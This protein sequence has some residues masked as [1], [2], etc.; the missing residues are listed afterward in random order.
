MPEVDYELCVPS[1]HL[2]RIE[3]AHTANGFCE[4]I[5]ELGDAP[6]E[7]LAAYLLHRGWPDDESFI[8][9][10]VEFQLYRREHRSARTALQAIELAYGH[11]EAP[12]LAPMQ[13]E[14]VMPQSLPRVKQERVAFLSW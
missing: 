7:K 2:Q 6:A 11:K 3:P 12:T 1:N 13:I 10:A 5:A 9:S 8:R 14:H 4:C